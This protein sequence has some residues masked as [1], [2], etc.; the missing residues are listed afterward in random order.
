MVKELIINKKIPGG[1]LTIDPYIKGMK[2]KRALFIYLLCFSIAGIVILGKETFMRKSSPM[3]GIDVP[4]LE[5]LLQRELGLPEIIE[6]SSKTPHVAFVDQVIPHDLVSTFPTHHL[7]PHCYDTLDYRDHLIPSFYKKKDLIVP[8]PDPDQPNHCQWMVEGFL[9]ITQDSTQRLYLPSN[10]PEDLKDSFVF[11]Q[12]Q[13][14]KIINRQ[15]GGERFD[16]INCSYSYGHEIYP[17]ESYEAIKKGALVIVSA[18]NDYTGPKDLYQANYYRLARLAEDL[19]QRPNMTGAL[20][21]VGAYNPFDKTLMDYSNRPLSEVPNSGDHFVC[22][23]GIAIQNGK[24][25][26]NG[27]TS[28]AA[29]YVSGVASLLM[30][31]F[32]TLTAREIAAIIKQGAL[33]KP[34]PTFFQETSLHPLL[35]QGRVNYESSVQ[36]G[37][38][39]LREKGLPPTFLAIDVNAGLRNELNPKLNAR[40]FSIY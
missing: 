1:F 34:P 10:S 11:P 40:A 29:A 24:A 30:K 33:G 2:K 31:R 4:G 20:L 25:Y 7:D 21:I 22:A 28:I 15:N 12:P 9:Q 37:L 32:P 13:W 38:D 19:N 26:P 18:G 8:A 3:K 6:T 5:T 39:L 35:G 17:H 27:G 36:A 23:P 14:K 16:I